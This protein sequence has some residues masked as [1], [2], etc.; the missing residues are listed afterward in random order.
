MI[1]RR[2]AASPTRPSRWK[3]SES[4]PRCTSVAAISSSTPRS[5]LPSRRATP[6]IPH[7]GGTLRRQATSSRD[8]PPPQD[9]W[10]FLGL[11]VGVGIARRGPLTID[12]GAPFPGREQP[13]A[14]GATPGLWRLASAA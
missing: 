9:L 10:Q 2:R 7:I 5:A 11:L 13:L 14:R 1:D 12:G 6:Q 8:R 3:P 4:G